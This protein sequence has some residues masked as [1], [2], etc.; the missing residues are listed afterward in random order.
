MVPRKIEELKVR[1]KG[2]R[3]S[4]GTRYFKGRLNGENK[5]VSFMSKKREI[6]NFSID[7]LLSAINNSNKNSKIIKEIED[8][9]LHL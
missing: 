2:G 7:E 9:C 8:S 3:A 6:R 1:N 5:I 4:G